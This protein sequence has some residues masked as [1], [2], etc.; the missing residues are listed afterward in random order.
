MTCAITAPSQMSIDPPR[1]MTMSD[2]QS[3][4]MKRRLLT[5][6]ANHRILVI[7]HQVICHC[8]SSD[9]SRQKY[10][11]S[12]QTTFQKIISLNFFI[13]IYFLWFHRECCLFP[14][15]RAAK[16]I[17]RKCLDKY[18]IYFCWFLVTFLFSS[19]KE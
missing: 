6:L 11:T 3:S 15:I 18:L 13:Y 17:I 2:Q 1:M 10:S 19:I 12:S 7:D 5:D 8:Q 9:V 4:I 14:E 16:L